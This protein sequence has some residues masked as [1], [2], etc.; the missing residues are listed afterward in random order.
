VAKLSQDPDGILELLLTYVVAYLGVHSRD[1]LHDGPGVVGAASRQ[2]DL[3]SSGV[4]LV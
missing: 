3:G 1:H 4:S 2:Y